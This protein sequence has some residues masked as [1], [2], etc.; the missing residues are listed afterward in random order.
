[1]GKASVATRLL[2]VALLALVLLPSAGS[3]ARPNVT[4]IVLFPAYHLNRL[5]VDVR[6]QTVAPQC[7]RSGT[8]EYWFQNPQHSAF[9]QTCQDQLLTLR[10]AEDSDRPM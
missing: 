7:P 3:A 9:S 8:F 1:M 2:V 5:T 6:N 4:P 10:Y